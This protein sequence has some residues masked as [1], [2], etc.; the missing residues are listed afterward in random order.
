MPIDGEVI[1]GNTY[2]DESMITGESLPVHK[3][4]GDEVIGGTI[5]GKGSVTVKVTRI[6]KDTVLAKVIRLVEEAQFTKALVQ[7]LADKV[8]GVF[9]PIVILI[10][11]AAFLYGIFWDLTRS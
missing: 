5:N 11:I 7:R 10:S 1:D 6:G 8:A 2:V 9:V 3:N 4:V